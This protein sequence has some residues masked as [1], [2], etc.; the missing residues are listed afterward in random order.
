M[1]SIAQS[2]TGQNGPTSTTAQPPQPTN[3]KLTMYSLTHF[4]GESKN[5][6]ENLKDFDDINFD[7]KIA[8]VK[9]G[10]NCCWKL[11]IDANFMPVTDHLYL[12]HGEYPSSTDIQMVFKKASSAEKVPC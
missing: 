6:T 12:S 8:S 5:L 9:L 7:D 3:C 1:A 10:G 11:Y 4:R 2:S